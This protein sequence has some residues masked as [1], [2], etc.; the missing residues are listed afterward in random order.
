MLQLLP[1]NFSLE[2]VAQKQHQRDKSLQ[3]GQKK[4]VHQNRSQTE[5]GHHREI[6]AHAGLDQPSQFF[7]QHPRLPHFGIQV[8]DMDTIPAIITNR[9]EL[10]NC[11]SEK[12]CCSEW[13]RTIDKYMYF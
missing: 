5:A 9:A 12:S 2:V 1:S 7:I 11:F 6:N 10:C 3:T 13:V 4:F 8:H